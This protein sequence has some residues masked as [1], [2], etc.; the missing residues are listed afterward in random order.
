MTTINLEQ[1]KKETGFTIALS[2]TGHLYLETGIKARELVA[3]EIA[4]KIQEFWQNDYAIGLL[5]LGLISLPTGLTPS[6]SFWQEFSRE[7][8]AQ[9]CRYPD[10]LET[11]QKIKEIPFPTQQELNSFLEKVP[12]MLGGE[13]LSLEVLKS[14]WLDLNQALLRELAN[15][16]F[17]IQ[18][19]FSTYHANWNLVGR[20]CFNLAENKDNVSH[21]FAFLATYTTRLT[22]I[23]QLQHLP[24]GKA[25][26]EYAGEKNKPLLLALLMPIQKAA[27]ASSFIKELVDSSN[28][29]KPLAWST[30]DAYKFLKETHLFESAGIVV[31]TPNWWNAK[32]PNRPQVA[33][34]IGKNKAHSVGIDALLDFDIQLTLADGQ[35][36]TSEE[37]QEILAAQDN[38]IKVKGQW[39]EV[40]PEKLKEVLTHW[41][42]VQSEVARGGLS[43]SEGMRL[44]SG[45]G[46]TLVD[47]NKNIAVRDWSTI[48]AGNW[49]QEILHSLRNPDVNV[50][51]KLITI[52]KEHLKAHLRH[53]Q[54]AGVRWL[55]LLYN[56]KLGGCLAD[57]MG[58]GKTIQ[59]LSLLLLI[60]YQEKRK[61]QKNYLL[62]SLIVVPAS[63]LGNW[64]AEIISFAPTLR[65]FIA[66]SSND[67]L[68]QFNP[69][70]LQNYDVI[71]TTY[72]FLHRLPWL[73]QAKWNVMVLDEAQVIKNAT[74]KQTHAAKALAA[75]VRFILTGT[76]IENNLGDLWSL[77]DFIASG[78][79]G[80]QKA[81][82]RYGKKLQE[83]DDNKSKTNFFAALRALVKPYILRRMKSDKTIISDL[84][85]KTE[86]NAYCSL[87][88]QQISL[89]Q[90]SVSELTERLRQSTGIERRVIVLAYLLRL[91]QICN[92]PCQWLGYGDYEEH[93]SGKFLRL[94]ELCTAIATKQEKVLVFTQFREIIPALYKHLTNTFQKEGLILHGSINVKQRSELVNSFQEEQGPPF[95]I[96]SLKAGG[97]GLN[98]TN[99]AHVIHFDRWW[100][101]AVENQATDRA[102]RIG[103]KKNVLVHKFICSGTIE[104][105]IDTIINDKKA[106][107]QEILLGGNE[108]ILTELSNE[109][110]LQ[111]VSL[112]INRVLGD[113]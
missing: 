46:E 24:L 29:F 86:L 40:D 82:G 59:I 47:D 9:V 65:F 11:T 89:Y 76:P 77:F 97:T 56:L 36:L 52:L 45:F 110:L 18:K 106:L 63:L 81:F 101:P 12:F 109:E 16:S 103:Q 107:S 54:I 34:A 5:H 14:L 84:P 68:K 44:L 7:F 112:D 71:F 61:N 17:D 73:S 3:E 93:A 72:S 22:G 75:E 70:Q 49:L 104:E 91:K 28:I 87:S 80:S 43:F 79:L 69:E 105:K 48:S 64:Q 19:Y 10:I 13:Y 78:L 100:N 27:A 111:V 102:Y 94:N 108:V 83:Q 30:Q 8:I 57:D 62:P 96:L 1:A 15:Y 6:I 20:V 55:W 33:V 51:A 99:A 31:R 58:L 85:D 88:K 74:A 4:Q 26:Q 37:W 32:K 38:L 39:V 95:F 98:L 67:N 25:L 35:Q 113:V 2:P 90:Q 53:Y 21:P 66:H 23:S 42:Q 92:H 60:K 41:H 50:D